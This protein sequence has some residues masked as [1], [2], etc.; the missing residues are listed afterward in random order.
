MFGAEIHPLTQGGQ[1]DKR[2]S[3]EQSG[4]Q[5]P[6][7]EWTWNS[8]PAL[9]RN[10]SLGLAPVFEKTLTMVFK[11]PSLLGSSL[12]FPPHPQTSYICSPHPH[13]APA[14]RGAWCA[15]HMPQALWRQSLCTTVASSSRPRLHEEKQFWFGSGNRHWDIFSCLNF[16]LIKILKIKKRNFYVFLQS[17]QGSF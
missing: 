15:L 12:L 1:S 7:R 5:W 4:A 17:D 13:F 10:L 11:N 3:L 2:W 9:K 6:C 16:F 14:P 8:E